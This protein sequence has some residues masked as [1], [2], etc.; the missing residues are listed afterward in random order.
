MNYSSVCFTL[1][2]AG[3]R[4][5]YWCMLA[6]TILLLVCEVTISQLCKSLITLVNGFHTLFILLCMALPHPPPHTECMMKPPLSSL[7]FPASAPHNSTSSAA[8]PSTLPADAPIKPL[9]GTQA[10]TDGQA[11]PDQPPTPQANYEA[12]SLV[13]CH[14]L[15]SSE[16][17]HPALTCGVSY[18]N[19]RIQP[20]GT[21]FSALLL[22][23]L[24]I[25]YLIEI[26]SFSLDP[27]PVQRPLMLVVVGAVSLLH[28]MLLLRLNWDQLHDG[29]TGGH[30][31]PETEPHIEV[32]HK[33][34]VTAQRFRM[35]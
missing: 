10:A 15:Y 21:F 24:C 17:S 8:P 22:A 23:S 32:N 29:R 9:A 30:S 18:T 35:K 28:K 1:S 34:N 14:Q 5:L 19:S 31:Q 12:A 7:D 26:I 13:N 6:V 3:M 16:V 11:V 4:V 20:V 33:G 2:V 27:H 25:S